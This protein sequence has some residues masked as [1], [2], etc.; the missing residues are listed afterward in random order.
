GPR[1]RSRQ[2]GPGRGLSAPR[3]A[4]PA[5][6]DAMVTTSP[7]RHGS[8]T[9]RW[10]RMRPTLITQ[11][12]VVVALIAAFAAPGL[13]QEPVPPAGADTTTATTAATAAPATTAPAKVAPAPAKAT[14]TAKATT[15]PAE[16][17]PS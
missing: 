6:P 5:R 13:A 17:A 9:H 12:I 3:A 10:R 7:A 16:A 15:A 1:A 8:P 11:I 2:E 4:E 14:T